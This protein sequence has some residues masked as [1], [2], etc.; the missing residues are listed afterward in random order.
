MSRLHERIARATHGA[1]GV[2]VVL[3]AN[4][5]HDTGGG[6]RSAQ[7]A[8]ELLERDHAVV[9]VSHGRVTE[10]VDLGLRFEHPRLVQMPLR[11][12]G[13]RSGHEAVVGALRHPGASVLT[14]VPVRSWM[15][16]LEAAHR[17]G[18]PTVY[19]CVD[20]WDSELGRGW[21]RRHV[22]EAVGS[23][24][25]LLVASAPEL[26]RHVERLAEREVHLLPNAFNARIFAPDRAGERPA[27]LPP[28]RVALYVGALWG[29][30]LDW[31]LV[32]AAAER[33]PG[34]RFVFV[35]DHRGEG[36]GLPSNCVFLGLKPQAELPP[37][38]AHADLAFVPWVTD[39]VTQATSP[40]KV[41]E[42]VAM[43]LPV[44][45]PR[46]DT[47][48]GIPGVSGARGRPEFLE[49]LA[50]ADRAATD[51][52]TREAMRRFAGASSWTHRVDVL[53]GLV[54]GAR[55][56]GHHAA[57]HRAPVRHRTRD[58]LSVVVP[59]YNHARYVGAAVGSVRA[60]TLPV[61]DL[62]VVDDGSTDDSRAVLEA[63][64]FRGMRCVFQEN[65]GAHEA[66]NRAIARSAGEYVAIL[67]SDDL[68]EPERME[69]AWGVARE[70]GAA[71][72]I[73]GVRWIGEDAAPLPEDHPAVRWYGEALREASVARTLRTAVRR[74][75]VAV[76]T[77]NF[78]LHRELW[79][80]LG[81]FRGYRYAHDLD[82][83]LRALEL[84]PDRV[85]F[86][87]SM[88]DVRYRIHGANTISENT[89]RAL[90]ERARVVR[91]LRRPDTWLRRALARP[92]RRAAIRKAVTGERSLRP[93][94]AE[95]PDGRVAAELADPS[96]PHPA[97]SAAVPLPGERAPPARERLLARP[98][99][100]PGAADAATAVALAEPF[101]SPALPELAGRRAADARPLR[102]GI[103]VR[104]LDAGGLEEIVALLART[105]PAH[106][107]EPHVLC[108]HGGGA[109]ARR[110][111]AAGVPV[112]VA[113]GR[114]SRWREWSHAA[115]PDVIS[116]H[117][118]APDV[119]DALAGGPPLVETVHNTYAWLRAEGWE[120]E[121]RKLE[122]LDATVA[123]S[124]LVA[125]YHAA[126]TATE[127]T[128]HVIPNAVDPARVARV[129]RVFARRR[130]GLAPDAPVLVHLGR[131]AAQKNLAGLVRA[132]AEVERRR[133]GAV[134]LLAGPAPSRRGTRALLRLRPELERRR[135]LRILPPPAHVGSLLSAAD[136]YVSN[137]FF[138][139]WSVAA[140]EALWAGVPV[141]AS[142]CGG[143]WELVGEDGA[144]GRVVP[145]PAG[146][147]L[148]VGPDTL[149]APP[150]EAARRNE[151][152]LA[153]ALLEVLED[154]PAWAGAAAEIRAWALERLAPHRM[155]ASYASLFRCLVS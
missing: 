108:T 112:T 30:W 82:F 14:Q 79:R 101:A 67:N 89:E 57:T 32:R 149:G 155:A 72:V 56:A 38:L 96:A 17:A 6:Q 43:G 119:I 150:P 113:G 70:A 141:V 87:P 153:D 80:A 26:V 31:G 40:L 138:E 46:L 122:R 54:E 100:F 120:G 34:T 16:V 86:E 110:L 13:T 24:S 25:D 47:L 145:N 142:E 27:D 53:L 33:H 15:P 48:E 60:Q 140:S 7:I 55:R 65:R 126:R 29:G 71:L 107:I 50:R 39:A 5:M 143:A 147:P 84:C 62:V 98:E 139:G 105:L 61:A 121:R 11:A 75:N 104:S 132:F 49:L 117:F 51:P 22:E 88:V 152:A 115:R 124:A 137:S 92:G 23:A 59:S 130:L 114:P 129:P 125:R 20:R 99:P 136:A 78:F 4:P 58:V 2:C 151:A 37:Y 83:L 81:G 102:A 44:V 68:L 90:R 10:T 128:P 154:R 41:Y 111:R 94:P 97:E 12:V 135:A 118:A 63:Q 146:E 74:H 93:L 106:G 1:P 131:F 42:F 134:L 3:S 103:V 123:V 95:R 35:G 127:P 66:I 19:D 45:A 36:A 8:L 133:P 91:S 109:V 9:F 18:A 28:G 76:T 52:E 77:S 85:V 148:A 73:G 144:R 116:T 21:Y 64:R 69:H